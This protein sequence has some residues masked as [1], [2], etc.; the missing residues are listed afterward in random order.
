MTNTN[1]PLTLQ[2]EGLYTFLKEVNL[3]EKKKKKNPQKTPTKLNAQGLLLK[4]EIL[5][6]FDPN[7]FSDRFRMS[8]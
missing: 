5:S 3:T 4:I 7:L 1:Q 8:H 2:Q 6:C